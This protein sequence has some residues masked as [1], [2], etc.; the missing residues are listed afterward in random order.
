MK[1]NKNYFKRVYSGKSKDEDTEHSIF[2]VMVKSLAI[3]F[4]ISFVMIILYALMLSFSS[5]SDVSMSKV[6]QAILILSIAISSIYGSKK[7][8]QRGWMF[9]MLLGLLFEL[10]LIPFGMAFGQSI[11]FDVY[12]IAKLLVSA[13]VGAIGG[14]IGVNLN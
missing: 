1:R 3:C 14:I 11:S 8:K 13:V 6:T 7:L 10:M 12:I 4:I 9:G 2:T 5:M